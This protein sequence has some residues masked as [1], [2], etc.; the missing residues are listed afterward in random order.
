MCI[1]VLTYLKISASLFSFSLPRNPRA[2]MASSGVSLQERT[3]S[4]MRKLREALGGTEEE[5]QTFHIR[6]PAL[7]NSGGRPNI[8]E[9]PPEYVRA[10]GRNRF[11]TYRLFLL[12]VIISWLWLRPWPSGRRPCC[13]RLWLSSHLFLK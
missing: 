7:I 9:H 5:L 13:R 10:A 6:A 1:L 8:L 12:K 2:K 11:L 4:T 3:K